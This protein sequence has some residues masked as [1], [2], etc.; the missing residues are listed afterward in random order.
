MK[1]IRNMSKIQS[2]IF[3]GRRNLRDAGIV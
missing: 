3:K 1:E 2:E